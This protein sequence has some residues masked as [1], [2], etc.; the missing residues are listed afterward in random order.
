M[1]DALGVRNATI[2]ESVH[3]IENIQKVVAGVPEFMSG[4]LEA[5]KSPKKTKFETV[6]PALTTF[7]D[8]VV[9]S[10]EMKPEEILDYLPDVGFFLSFAVVLG[11]ENKMAF[12]GAVSLGD[13][14]QNG[15]TVLGPAIADAAAWYDCPEMIGVF[16]TPH[17]GNFLSS[18]HQAHPL[19]S[20]EFV[21]YSVPLKG[22]AS[23]TLWAAGWPDH[24][25]Y[26]DASSQEKTATH[27]Y[28]ELIKK[29]SIPKGTED[30]YFNTEKFVKWILRSAASESTT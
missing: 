5:S 8:T 22:G 7:G 6:P 9:F 16:A 21:E 10:W 2:E 23:K 14:I 28:Y 27:A 1:I 13:Y 12:R 29:F 20:M 30:K 17:C 26:S 11:L 18:I 24:L 25:S 15:S 4:Y 3:F 19:N